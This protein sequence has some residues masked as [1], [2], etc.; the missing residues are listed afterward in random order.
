MLILVA[1]G[2]NAI[3]QRGDKGSYEE[4]LKNVSRTCKILADIIQMGHKLVITHGNGPQVGITMIRYEA[5]RKEVPPYPL[6]VA[7]AE[8]Q[9]FIGYMIQQELTNELKRRGINKEVVTIITRVI[10]DKNDPAFKNPTKPIGPF[11]TKEEV[12]QIK[13]MHP[14]WVIIED[15]G[16]G[17][18]RVVPSPYPKEIVELNA[19]KALVNSGYTVIACGGGGIPVIRE[20]GRLIG[21]DAVI[22]KDLASERLATALKVDVF[23]ILTDVEGAYLNYGTSSAKLL[24]EVSLEEIKKYYSEGH[25][26]PGSMGPKIFAAIKFLEN[27]GRHVIIGKLDKALEA[28]NNRSGTHIYA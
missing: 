21:V 6:H 27:G 2:G 5:A 26:K 12:E 14:D 28:L 11:Y 22:D 4:Q 7:D 8:S 17:Y 10:V 3:Y 1:L 24:R 16:R 23:M 15:C 20:N 13:K 18:R 9:G 25:F 19:I